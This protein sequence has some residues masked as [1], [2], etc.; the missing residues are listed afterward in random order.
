MKRFR[1]MIIVCC[2]LGG[3]PGVFY[4]EEGAMSKENAS[5]QQMMLDR[6]TRLLTVYQA[7][8]QH[9]P[10][11]LCRMGRAHDGGYVVPSLAMTHASAVMGYGICDDISFEESASRIYEKP[12]YGFDGTC[13]KPKIHHRLCHFIPNNIVPSG[14]DQDAATSF[15]HQIKK[16]Q[17]RDSQ[18]FIKMDIEGNEYSVMADILRHASQITGIVLEIHFMQED[19]V[20]LALSLLEAIDRHF[21]LVH[22]HGNNYCLKS[23]TSTY[24]AGSIPC[25]LELSYV[26]RNLVQSYTVAADQSHPT[27]LD[28]PNNASVSDCTFT[29]ITPR[30]G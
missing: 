26:N 12:S 21:L 1:F 20:P 5:E 13:P 19:Q 4:G 8:D 14:M 2:V 18:L 27:P 25:V 3:L 28:M 9:G 22:V 17:L 15:D 24:A 23:F 7:F 6:V 30:K 29:L 16:L 11:S 10:L